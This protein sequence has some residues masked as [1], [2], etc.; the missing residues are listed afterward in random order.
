VNKYIK[1]LIGLGIIGFQSLAAAQE[2]TVQSPIFDF[3]VIMTDSNGNP[4]TA[5]VHTFKLENKSEALLEITDIRTSCTCSKASIISRNIKKGTTAELT[6]EIDA[7]GLSGQISSDILLEVQKKSYLKLSVKGTLVKPARS[8]P[9]KLYEELF[10]GESKGFEF[11]VYTL[12]TSVD[13]KNEIN[14]RVAYP[15]V[16]LSHE[17]SK[18]LERKSFDDQKVI[19]FM[20]HRFKATVIAK[21]TTTGET[22][23]LLFRPDGLLFFKIPLKII[24]FPETSLNNTNLYVGPLKSGESRRQKLKI[25]SR[26]SIN[27]VKLDVNNFAQKFEIQSSH[28][29]FTEIEFKVTNSGIKGLQQQIGKVFIENMSKPLTFQIHILGI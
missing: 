1:I 12:E 25:R 4:P 3:G 15:G 6:V 20:V 14:A 21:E 24:I 17:F 18:R 29:D 8:F 10:E 23:V 2:L 7:A 9:S 16:I 28:S 19:S 11:D 26:N 27:I 5:L 22:E 13:S